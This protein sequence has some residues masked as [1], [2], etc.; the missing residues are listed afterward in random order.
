MQL[1]SAVTVPIVGSPGMVLVPDGI[2]FV[3]VRD[4]ELKWSHLSWTEST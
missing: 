2:I 1:I 3:W 4:S